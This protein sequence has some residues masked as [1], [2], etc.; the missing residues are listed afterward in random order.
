MD[1]GAQITGK[2]V[3]V[4]GAS[5]GLGAHFARLA[6]RHGAAVVIGAR[7]RDR[8][9][10]LRQTLER[11]GAAAAAA[12]DLDVADEA[13]AEKALAAAEAAVG[14][15]DILVNNAGI[16]LHAPA[17]TAELDNWRRMVDLNL[18][19]LLASTHAALPHLVRAA[20][21]APRGVADL[22]SIG[23]VVENRVIAINGVYAGTKRAVSAMTESLRQEL[24]PRYV[25]A[26]VVRPGG[27]ATEMQTQLAHR[28]DP[29]HIADAIV[30]IV[31]RPRQVAVHE[32]VVRPTE[33]EH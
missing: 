30:Y 33:Q 25:R 24:A 17:A 11:E 31:T 12:V 9:E 8:L 19:A 13:S 1:L 28:I 7:R 26:S 3:F 21:H 4:T 14:T 18:T 20:E 16:A 5:G 32:I 2:R 23:S 29:R 6:A 27:V 15:I 10:S 22:V